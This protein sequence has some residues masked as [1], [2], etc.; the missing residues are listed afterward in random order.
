[1][2]LLVAS[3]LRVCSHVVPWQRVAEVNRV[4]LPEGFGLLP[5]RPSAEDV[6]GR[7]S[8]LELFKPEYRLITLLVWVIW[9]RASSFCVCPLPAFF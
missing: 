6:R 8:L 2:L 5:Y 9:V 4:K 1:M 7:A 3:S